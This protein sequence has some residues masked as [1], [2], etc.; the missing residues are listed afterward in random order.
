MLVVI[1]IIAVLA[2]ILLPALQSARERGRRATCVNNLREIGMAIHM[3][4]DNEGNIGEFSNVPPW[5]YLYALHLYD[6]ATYLME[7]AD[8]SIVRL[9]LLLQDDGS[10]NLV[11]VY[12]Q[13]QGLGRLFPHFINNK[14]VF[15]CPS[16]FVWTKSNA[17]PA[18][19]LNYYSTYHSR[20]AA[21]QTPDGS[22]Y[23]GVLPQTEKGF[24]NL[25]YVACASWQG[26]AA[27][28][29]GWNVLFLD[30]SVHWYSL[31][32]HYGIVKQLSAEEW[33]DTVMGVPKVGRPSAWIFFDLYLDLLARPSP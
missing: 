13:P 32:N 19:D 3:F 23:F 6:P 1:A 4:M 28:V 26:Y 16:S 29:D 20:E 5:R 27:H 14:D 21:G 31:K 30:N 17:W 11:P 7:D 2:A 18:E 33:F 25:S 9:F 24:R 15:Y 22:V 12:T 10:G 8:P